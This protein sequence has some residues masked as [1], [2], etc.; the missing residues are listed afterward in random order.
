M[1]W[2]LCKL[3][4]RS[5]SS[6]TSSCLPIRQMITKGR[7]A[8]TWRPVRKH[9]LFDVP[10]SALGAQLCTETNRHQF[11]PWRMERKAQ[12]PKC[13]GLLLVFFFQVLRSPGDRSFTLGLEGIDYQ[14]VTRVLF[15]PAPP[16][17]G[18][19]QWCLRWQNSPRK[20][21]FISPPMTV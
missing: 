8:S 3:G 7:S 21:T 13:Y 4:L 14:V 20:T 12:L 2:D 5:P 9:H 1:S 15:L 16:K 11:A 19:V 17:A 10:H 18:H 6:C